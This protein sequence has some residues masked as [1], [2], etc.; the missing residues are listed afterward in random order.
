MPF[1][2]SGRVMKKTYWQSICISNIYG[3]MAVF[4]AI[5]CASDAPIPLFPLRFSLI[6]SLIFEIDQGYLY[7]FCTSRHDLSIGAIKTEILHCH[8][9]DV[10][11]L[12]VVLVPKNGWI[13]RS[14]FLMP[15]VRSGRVMKKLIDSQYGSR[16]FTELWRFLA[17]HSV[18]RALRFR[19]F[20]YGFLSYLRCFSR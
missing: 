19:D 10:R 4:S 3:V 12:Y 1:V 13:R 16:I 8:I 2:R 17:R 7:V 15:F 5:Q 9:F 11:V 18:R 20:R 14:D 6:S